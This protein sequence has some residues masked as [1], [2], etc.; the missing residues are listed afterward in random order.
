MISY[1]VVE[2]RI[3][4]LLINS[5]TIVVHELSCEFPLK[6]EVDSLRMSIIE[7]FQD[8]ISKMSKIDEWTNIYVEKG[9]YL[10]K[11][12]IEPMLPWLKTDLIIITDDV[13]G[14]IP[15]ELLLTQRPLNQVAFQDYP[16]LLKEYN[17]SYNYSAS[18]LSEMLKNKSDVEVRKNSL[19][20]APFV[21][22]NF[23]E[24][25]EKNYPEFLSATRHD[26]LSPLPFSISE[27]ASIA[28]ITAGD[29]W[30]GETAT[31]DK[32]MIEAQKYKMLHIAT[33]AIVDDQVA[34]YAF[35]AMGDPDD[36]S[37]YDKLY[38]RDIYNMPLNAD[39]VTLSACR[40]GYGKIQHGE[41]VISLARAF[42][43]A[44]SKS[45]ITTHWNVDDK[46]TS[47]LMKSFYNN[48]MRGTQKHE[49]LRSAKIEFLN[50]HKKIKAHPFY[51]GGVFAIGDMSPID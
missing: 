32:F 39:M 44:G 30:Y 45:I 29:V 42:A 25:V 20:I 31:V 43:Y 48:L 11:R 50:N 18:L 8:N 14:Y 1:T 17:I 15:F 6:D 5:D 4:S 24:L 33:H 22:K 21:S 38:V 51:W 7:P 13:L 34:D 2:D 28:K 36:P 37:Q 41:G 10:Y 35:L 47:E 40:T 26:T 19:S 16:Y 12:L 46:S 27:T 9:Y 49:A 3:Y 23:H